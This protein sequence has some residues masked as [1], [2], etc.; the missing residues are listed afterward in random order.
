MKLTE[1]DIAQ[2]L[3]R[4]MKAET[5]EAQCRRLTETRQPLAV[6]RPAL[7]GDG[8]RVLNE[9]E[10]A[11]LV[12][13]Y[14]T[15]AQGKKLLKFVPASGAATRMFKK[16]YAADGFSAAETEEVAKQLPRYP[17]YPLLPEKLRQSG[18]CRKMIA[19]LLS[20][21]GLHYGQTPKGLLPFHRYADGVRT[22][23]EEH[24][25]E[26]AAY[27]ACSDGRVC[28]HF[29]VSPEHEAAFRALAESLKPRYEG[30]SGCRYE[31]DFSEQLPYTDTVSLTESGELLRDAEG[32]VVF[33][34]GGHG[35]LL[36]NLNRLDADVVF[37]KNI[38]NVTLDARKADTYTYKKCLAALLLRVQQ[39][40][41]QA[42][43]RLEADASA[44]A[45]ASAE[46]LLRDTL[47][48][49]FPEGYASFGPE[50]RRRFCQ[51]YLHRPIRVCG[52]VPREKEPGGG[53]F[54][55]A[56]AQGVQSLQIVETAE[57]DLSD[58]AQ[59]QVLEDSRYFN[60]VDLVCGLKDLHGHP[61][62]LLRHVDVDRYFTAQKSAEGKNIKVLEHPGLWNGS[63]SDWITLFVAVPLTTF[64]PVKTVE[65]LLRP[66]HLSDENNGYH[67]V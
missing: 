66:A 40:C 29:T 2:C 15:L 64:S 22:A 59:R 50:E 16:W 7:P 36:H 60:P 18:D 24:F 42:L 33:R 32:R 39:G 5:I 53:P 35:S 44:E 13:E 61:Y 54:W 37:I 28:L 52:M 63:M 12:A 48:A 1:K 49:A 46:S 34:P 41:F 56:D 57:M 20:P 26:A 11:T 45:L 62:D 10:T 27:A 3:E 58:A 14:E 30:L 23:F 43:R 8:I 51:C 19:Y 31:V 55:V 38:D 47:S 65:D 17:F 4:G 21:E 67:E 6:L 25:V 9:A